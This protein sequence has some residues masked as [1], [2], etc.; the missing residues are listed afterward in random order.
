MN[1]GI[2][3]KAGI[4]AQNIAQNPDLPIAPQNFAPERIPDSNG[5]NGGVYFELNLRNGRGKERQ[6]DLLTTFSTENPTES[7]SF[8]VENPAELVSFSHENSNR[9]TFYTDVS[10]RQNVFNDDAETSTESFSYSTNR[11][12]RDVYETNFNSRNPANNSPDWKQLS[13]DDFVEVVKNNRDFIEFRDKP[14]EFWRDVRR[15]SESKNIETGENS[16]NTFDDGS[17]IFDRKE[18]R[19]SFFDGKDDVKSSAPPKNYDEP[20][21]QL[22]DKLKF[23]DER[24]DQADDRPKIYESGKESVG[25]LDEIKPSV[26]PVLAQPSGKSESPKA[27][28]YEKLVAEMNASKLSPDEF[29]E[30]L[31]PQDKEIFKARYQLDVTFGAKDLISDEVNA[32]Q[33]EPSHVREIAVLSKENRIFTG[34][35]TIAPV[36]LPKPS[37]REIAF[38]AGNIAPFSENTFPDS[39]P[40]IIEPNDLKFQDKSAQVA[41][42]SRAL[43]LTSESGGAARIVN[44]S[45]VSENSTNIGAVSRRDGGAALGGALISGAF[46]SIENYKNAESGKI[47]GS[48]LFG[49]ADIFGRGVF[50]AGATG[51]M[52]S[53]AVGSVIPNGNATVGGVLG[54]ISSVVVGVEADQG[55]R[56]LGGDRPTA[57]APLS[58]FANS[59]TPN[60][61]TPLA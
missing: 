55:L 39:D 54:F 38:A 35:D 46:T 37:S 16:L 22:K 33:S 42:G 41:V 10:A 31:P 56:W 47:G 8:S 20:F 13:L 27:S 4:K 60:L 50:S 1:E 45:T 5:E 2:E 12:N 14:N 26:P 49:K 40:K 32:F 44:H 17:R 30:T 7:N 59:F 58:S 28:K 25:T 19:S 18:N 21:N 34:K 9:K 52:M 53:A 23:Y 11:S 57:V 61:Q 48:D 36:D 51:A 15:F 24:F 43:P 6:Q 29:A 3:I